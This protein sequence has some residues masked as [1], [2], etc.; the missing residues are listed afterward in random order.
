[1]TR[2]GGPAI[3]PGVS[4]LRAFVK[5]PAGRFLARYVAILS[6]G[7]T[8]LAL[9]PVNDGVV[10]R[11]TT[12]V[13]HEAKV[14]LNALGEGAVVRGQVLSSPRFAVSIYNGCNG[15][16][17]LLIFCSG[18]LAFPAPPARKVLGLLA[19]FLVIQVANVVRIVSLF[20]VGVFRPAWF[21]ASHVFVWQSLIILLG[22][23]MWLFWV[24]RYGLAPAER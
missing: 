18:V 2:A 15:L 5:T 8:V 6:V 1:M 10:N 17:A 21:Q 3:L 24:H 16:E 23:V 22:V 11:Y 4:D 19:G 20:Y 7:F 13:A 12:F 9:R 14:A